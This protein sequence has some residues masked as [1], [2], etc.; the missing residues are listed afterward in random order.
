[1]SGLVPCPGCSG[2]RHALAL[3]ET[4][5]AELEARELATRSKCEVCLPF[6]ERVPSVANCFSCCRHLC[7]AHLVEKTCPHHREGV[8]EPRAYDGSRR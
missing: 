7:A 1:M 6:G 2:L 5:V 8:H 3:L 4:R